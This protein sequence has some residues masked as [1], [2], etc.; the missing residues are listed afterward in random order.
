MLGAGVAE[1]AGLMTALIRK[2]VAVSPRGML[3]FILIMVGV[4]SSVATDAGYLILIPLGAAAFASV[5]RHPLAGMAACFAGVGSIFGVN[6][7]L[8]P[9]DAMIT[10]ITNEAINLIPGHPPITI[11]SNWYF[12]IACSLI[13]AIVAALLTERVIEPR[14]GPWKPAGDHVAEADHTPEAA[15]KES[16]GLS[17]PGSR[18]SS[19]SSWSCCSRPRGRSAPG[20]RHRRHHRRDAVHGQ[21][22]VHHRDAVPGRGIGYGVGAGTFKSSTDVANAVTKTF[23]GL[24][25]LVFMLLMIAQFIAFFNFSRIPNVLAITL[26]EFL[27]HA[28]SAP[29][30]C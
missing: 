8:S 17:S 24:G 15:A 27:G 21:P 22:A 11:V 6:L 29:S 4:L 7:I 2:L 20:S 30:R 14:L 25:G 19:R 28:G 13:L 3:S 16:R 9:S 18:S 5:G 26:A 12:A 1:G 23:S 10:E